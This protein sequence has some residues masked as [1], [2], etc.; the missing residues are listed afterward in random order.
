MAFQGPMGVVSDLLAGRGLCLPPQA[1]IEDVAFGI[2]QGCPGRS[3]FIEVRDLGSAEAHR[4]L[5]L[6]REVVGHEVEVD[7]VLA[8]ARLRYGQE[9][10]R[11]ERAVC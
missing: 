11:W 3:I 4:A 10:Q 7:P 8:M 9:H 2:G 6:S 1:D 5:N